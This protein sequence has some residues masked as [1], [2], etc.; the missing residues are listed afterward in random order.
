VRGVQTHGKT[1]SSAHAG[2]RTAVNLAGINCEDITRGMTLAAPG[3]LVATQAA[4]VEIEVL[5][6]ADIRR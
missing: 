6:G 1:V 3:S 4:D 2:Q 5:A